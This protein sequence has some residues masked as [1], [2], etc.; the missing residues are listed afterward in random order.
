MTLREK[1]LA[2]KPK[3]QSIEINGETY[4]LREATVGD[5]N[6]QIFETRSWLIQQAEQEN[7][8]L[9]QKMMKPLTKLSTVLAKNTALLNRLPTVYVTKTVH[10]CLTHLTLTISMRLPN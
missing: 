8:E 1:L 2:N 7:V 9:P 6:K 3:L 5:M 4:Y 10:Y